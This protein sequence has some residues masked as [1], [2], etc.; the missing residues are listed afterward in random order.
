LAVQLSIRTKV[1]TSVLLAAVTFLVASGFF[2]EGP[3]RAV[4]QRLLAEEQK[5]NAL[6][7]ADDIA[8]L[9]DWKERSK[10]IATR[11]ARILDRRVT[12][13]TDGGT[14]I[15]DTAMD[16]K[17]LENHAT[18]EEIVSARESGTGVFSRRSVST[19]IEYLYVAA[20]IDSGTRALGYARLAT[21]LS[22]IEATTSELRRSLLL[23]ALAATVIAILVGAGAVR[24]A[25]RKLVQMSRVADE[26]GQAELGRRIDLPGDDEVAR[27]GKAV[28]LMA[29]RLEGRLVRL[30]RDR[31]L[32][33]AV[34]DAIGEGIAFVDEQDQVLAANGAFKQLVGT[35][36]APEGHRL[37]D[38]LPDQPL[39]AAVRK[40]FMTFLEARATA[41][42]G[43]PA[44]DVRFRV[45]PTV[46]ANVG[47]VALLIT[48]D[49]RPNP[50][51]EEIHAEGARILARSLEKAN[52]AL[53]AEAEEALAIAKAATLLDETQ[54]TPEVALVAELTP[55]HPGAAEVPAV[56]VVRSR[57]AAAFELMRVDRAADG[58]PSVEVAP[59]TVTVRFESRA[60][61][62]SRWAVPRTS[63]PLA[64]RLSI[65][66]HELAV[67]LFEAG[68][69]EVDDEARRF[70]VRMPRA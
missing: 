42:V 68:G 13:V 39:E 30:T 32:L 47:T 65:L 23:N 52:L 7:L 57:V 64:D 17:A 10:E 45:L 8:H 24:V 66:R 56:Y 62:S 40:A 22:D 20:R 61:R 59:G 37:R 33:I 38:V 70:V 41:S 14:V 26:I 3:L 58:A 69:C 2:L 49:L 21:P 16:E 4:L 60:A 12:I 6:R 15:A 67:T 55:D 51:L 18:R 19:G 34:L 46:V 27:L 44:R 48:Q 53:P 50:R 54:P 9:P 31:A 25:T 1:V 43:T 5:R 28:N 36:T 35:G 63:E 11:A 29:E